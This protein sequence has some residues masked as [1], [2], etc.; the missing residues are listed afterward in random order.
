MFTKS[1]L[2][3]ALNHLNSKE[4]QE[5]LEL[6][7]QIKMFEQDLEENHPN[8]IKI[9]DRVPKKVNKGNY[10]IVSPNRTCGTTDVP[11]DQ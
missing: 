8:I 9:G 11:G 10:T 4:R 5:A 3:N 1:L 2:H 6:K 7:A